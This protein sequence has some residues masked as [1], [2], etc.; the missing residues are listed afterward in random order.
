M[1]IRRSATSSHRKENS[2]ERK[3][4]DV[5][6]FKDRTFGKLALDL[7]GWSDPSAVEGATTGTMQCLSVR[8]PWAAQ[9][10]QT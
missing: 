3:R 9:H 6:K 7:G 4:E 8:W 10:P 2:T 1:P 5:A